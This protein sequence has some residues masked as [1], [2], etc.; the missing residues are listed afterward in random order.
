MQ[1]KLK[2]AIYMRNSHRF[3]VCSDFPGPKE[4]VVRGNAIDEKNK[5]DGDRQHM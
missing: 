1:S 5:E 2:T 4:S 3:R